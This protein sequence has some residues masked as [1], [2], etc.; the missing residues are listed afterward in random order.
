MMILS[1][2]SEMSITCQKITIL[3]LCTTHKLLALLAII[4]NNYNQTL[5]K[6][7]RKMVI[8]SFI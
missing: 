2:L 5:S 8:Y 1:F 4:N 6:F 7:K 3:T